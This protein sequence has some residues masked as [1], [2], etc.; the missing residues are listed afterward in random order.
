MH[1]AWGCIEPATLTAHTPLII[2]TLSI[3]SM[4]LSLWV[5]F[6]YIQ[7]VLIF[8]IILYIHIPIFNMAFKFL[9]THF[10]LLYFA[11]SYLFVC[12]LFNFYSNLFGTTI[13]IMF[14]NGSLA[15]LLELSCSSVFV[16]EYF[17]NEPKKM[18]LWAG[19]VSIMFLCTQ[20]GHTIAH[21]GIM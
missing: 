16:F 6:K 13:N 19:G 14:F 12:V 18:S 5:Y 7:H 9:S 1:V 3:F 8:L 2:C 11:F 15:L 4:Y 10:N 17:F 20:T 21:S